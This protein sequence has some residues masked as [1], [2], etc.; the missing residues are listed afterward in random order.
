MTSILE[1]PKMTKAKK[2]KQKKSRIFLTFYPRHHG[3]SC[4]GCSPFSFSLFFVLL[5]SL[6]FLHF[7]SQMHPHQLSRIFKQDD[8]RTRLVA[9]DGGAR[10]LDHGMGGW[11]DVDYEVRMYVLRSRSI[12]KPH[13]MSSRLEQW[14]F[15]RSVASSPWGLN[16]T[17]ALPFPPPKKSESGSGNITTDFNFDTSRRRA[18]KMNI[19]T[20]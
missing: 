9:V 8:P 4:N 15:P 11:T 13:S 6:V 19:L 16:D 14:V 3:I 5:G 10:R 12:F 20:D 7:K 1:L 18:L 2:E 17:L